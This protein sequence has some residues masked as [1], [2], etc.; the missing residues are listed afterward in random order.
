M[1]GSGGAPVLAGYFNLPKA[2]GET[3]VATWDNYDEEWRA[4]ARRCAAGVVAAVTAGIFWP[5]AELAPRDDEEFAGLFHQGTAESID[6][7]FDRDVRAR[8]MPPL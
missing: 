8:S 3:A 1:A 7:A 6:P 4:A 5:P 2:V